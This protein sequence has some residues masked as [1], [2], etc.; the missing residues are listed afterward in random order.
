MPPVSSSPS[1]RLS[2]LRALGAAAPRLR[3]GFALPHTPSARLRRVLPLRRWKIAMV[4]L[5]VVLALMCMPL[6]SLGLPSLNT[7][8]SLFSFGVSLFQW[9]WLRAWS[10][11]AS[12]PGLALVVVMLG[13]EVVIARPGLLTVRLEVLGFGLAADYPAVGIRN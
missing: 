8:G 9:F 6:L 1:H 5:G 13:R 7:H 4:I 11:G 10:I 3:F 2:R 12:L